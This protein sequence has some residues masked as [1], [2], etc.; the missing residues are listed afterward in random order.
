VNV[1]RDGGI[2]HQR[3]VY[4]VAIRVEN[5]EVHVGTH[6]RVDTLRWDTNPQ[7]RLHRG[8]SGP[9]D[10]TQAKALSLALSIAVTEAIRMRTWIDRMN[11]DLSYAPPPAA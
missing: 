6:I 8:H 4:D 5:V 9:L 1:E 11:D 2:D 3:G 10:W 7:I